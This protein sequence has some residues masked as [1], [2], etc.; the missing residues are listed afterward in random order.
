MKSKA[1]LLQC[2]RH[3]QGVRLDLVQLWQLVEQCEQAAVARSLVLSM[4][5]GEIKDK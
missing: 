1:G 5:V 3:Y 4:D 2:F